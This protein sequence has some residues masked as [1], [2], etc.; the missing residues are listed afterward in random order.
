MIVP[1]CYFNKEFYFHKLLSGNVL[2]YIKSSLFVELPPSV[3]RIESAVSRMVRLVPR[4]G[5][6]STYC[7]PGSG[8][9]PFI[10]RTK[11]VLQ[12]PS[13]SYI[14]ISIFTEEETEGQRVKWLVQEHVVNK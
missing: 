8:T 12:P 1:P 7:V 2:K 9:G 11:S 5:P 10:D 4:K 14:V 6:Q 3:I 13:K